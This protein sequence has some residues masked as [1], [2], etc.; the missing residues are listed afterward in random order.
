MKDFRGRTFSTLASR[1][2]CPYAG[3]VEKAQALKLGLL[4]YL[5]YNLHSERRK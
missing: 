1:K 3:G 2:R 4:I 5:C